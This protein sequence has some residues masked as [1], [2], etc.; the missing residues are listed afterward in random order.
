MSKT[1]NRKEALRE[2]VLYALEKIANGGHRGSQRALAEQMAVAPGMIRRYLDG[3]VAVE[4]LKYGTILTLAKAS[5]LDPGTIYVWVEAGRDAAMD[6]EARLQGDIPP[7]GLTDLARRLLN[8]LE[9]QEQTLPEL[10]AEPTLAPI[11]RRID[12]LEEEA[13]MSF[14][15]MLRMAAATEAVIKVRRLETVPADLDGDDWEALSVLL[16]ATVKALQLEARVQGATS[17]P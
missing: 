10:E 12:A 13:G 8:E 16:D 5:R 15:R 2:I 1:H 3:E 14:P 6:H 17:S 9:A 11:R 4:A 7:F